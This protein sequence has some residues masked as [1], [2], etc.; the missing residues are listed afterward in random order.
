M[1]SPRGLIEISKP[2]GG[3][4]TTGAIH[5]GGYTPGGGAIHE[6][7]T[8]TKILNGRHSVMST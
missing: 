8:F 1:Y 5:E 2:F 3:L 4:Y 6:A 7:P